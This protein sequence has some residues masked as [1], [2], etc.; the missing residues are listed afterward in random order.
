[1][2]R[3]LTGAL[4]VPLALLGCALRL[5]AV[6]AEVAPGG[7]LEI[8]GAGFSERTQFSLAGSV[9]VSL[10]V[11]ELSPERANA[12]V[13]MAAP[14]GLYDLRA[15]AG[16]VTAELPD[17]VLVVS[18][19]LDVHFLDVEQG[20]ATLVVAPGGATL[21][22]DGGPRSAGPVLKEAIR[23]LARG[24]LDA[25]VLSHTDADH[26][27]GLVELLQGDDG[28]PGTAD[29]LVPELRLTGADDGSCTSQVCGDLRALRAWPFQ[30]PDVGDA[31][32]LPG[33]D[34]VDATVV[35][36]DGDVGAG[37]VTGADDDNERSVVVQLAFGGSSVLVTGDLT[38]GGD[39]EADVETALAARTGPIDVLRAS[40]HGSATSSA[41]SALAAWQP[42]AI[43]LSLG[44]DNPYCHPAPEVLG[45]LAALG[46][47]IFATGAG[48][49][50]DGARCG[51]ATDWPAQTG[52]GLGT[53][54]LTL[55]AD[56][57]A[58]IAGEPL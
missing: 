35:A 53:I 47:P 7:A 4:L 3:L 58:T 6:T 12:T 18:G 46:A 55:R 32:E 20:D 33:A 26:L 17:A 56:G 36:V 37:R 13:P 44:T 8:T 27:G 45:R 19:G 5:D 43:V 28:A 10:Q 50:A 40:H 54:S 41:A 34:G 9:E 52:A 24:R 16:G 39:G 25:V 14:S 21:L 42:R 38:G 2:V 49:V 15:V 22:I 1:M 51:G 29:D 11:T 48:I 23:T 31:I 57:T 30:T